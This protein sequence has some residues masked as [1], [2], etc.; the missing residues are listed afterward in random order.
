MDPTTIKLPPDLKK[1]IGRLA[2]KSSQSAHAWMIQA[3]RAETQRA[4]KWHEFIGDAVQAAKE[5][6][7]GGPVYEAEAVHQHLRLL[8]QKKTSRLK[9][10]SGK[11][12]T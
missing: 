3:L 9:P 8:A 11:N 2:R 12:R 5:L 10:V 1:K 6:D 4:E 7:Q